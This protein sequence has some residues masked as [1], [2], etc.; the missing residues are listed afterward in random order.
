[1]N[2]EILEARL[3]RRL[4]MRARRMFG[5]VRDVATHRRAPHRARW[6]CQV[7]WSMPLSV[8]SKV[9]RVA[10]RYGRA[11]SEPLPASV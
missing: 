2:G 1:M 3:V 9:V 6:P 7:G 4:R 5:G 8:T 11:L 10:E